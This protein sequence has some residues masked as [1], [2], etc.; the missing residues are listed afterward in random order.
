MSRVSAF[1]ASALGRVV[2]A[3]VLVAV[4]L[5][6]VERCQRARQAGKE[7]A[8]SAKQGEAALGSG[9]DAVGAVGAVSGRSSASDDLT[10]ENDDA[11]RKAPGAEAA[12][13][14]RLRDAG[15]DSLCKRAAYRDSEQCLQRAAAG[16][17]AG[18][19]TGRPSP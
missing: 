6:G 7:A 5:F 9:K 18:T 19:D 11:I 13:D 8:L 1:V 17:V 12:V 3:L 10:R 4:I 14:P 16:R 2:L 15:L